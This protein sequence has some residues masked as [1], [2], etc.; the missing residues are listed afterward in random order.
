MPHKCRSGQ[1]RPRRNRQAAGLRLEIGGPER[2]GL[3]VAERPVIND[4]ND[5]V[6]P[7][8]AEIEYRR[9]VAILGN[10]VVVAEPCEIE[11][12][13]NT[14]QQVI[15]EER[16]P[17]VSTAPGKVIGSGYCEVG[18][19]ICREAR[20][21]ALD[22]RLEIL[23]HHRLVSLV[24]GLNSHVHSL[25]VAVTNGLAVVVTHS[26]RESRVQRRAPGTCGARRDWSRGR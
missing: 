16:C 7:S 19:Q 23:I 17:D 6:G 18:M 2:D 21:V 5:R 3:A 13:G 22:S 24:V 25:C 9:D 14:W 1:R 11:Y 12:I 26:K 20:E 15:T 10:D 4:L 8:N